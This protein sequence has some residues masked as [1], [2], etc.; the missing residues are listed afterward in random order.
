MSNIREFHI[1]EKPRAKGDS[2]K[3]AVDKAK[4]YDTLQTHIAQDIASME[5]DLKDFEASRGVFRIG[6]T[7]GYNDGLIATYKNM[8]EVLKNY[9]E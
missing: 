2:L 1:P 6:Y 9:L 5:R 8:I 4:K 7:N 3:V